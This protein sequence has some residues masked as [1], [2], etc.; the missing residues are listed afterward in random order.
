MRIQVDSDSCVGSGQCALALPEVFDQDDADGTVVLLDDRP[1]AELH[2][3]VREA[4][5]RCPVQAI[6]AQ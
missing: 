1:P 5:S 2:D 4:A 3:A 6:T